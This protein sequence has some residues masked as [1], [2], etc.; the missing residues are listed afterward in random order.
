MA[1]LNFFVRSVTNFQRTAWSYVAIPLIY[2]F[3]LVFR[4]LCVA[5]FNPLFRA[6]G[7]GLSPAEIFFIGFAGL[8][9]AVSLI[10]VSAFATGTRL[11]N[12][13]PDESSLVN[14]DISLWSSAFVVLT[15]VI[16]G[17]LIAPLLKILK[18]NVVPLEKLKMRSRAKRALC[19]F[20]EQQLTDLRDD[21]DEFLQ[22]K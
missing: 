3:M 11:T 17:P 6:L 7:E 4:C 13:S 1:S 10:M 18:L 19:R 22:G 15:L 9:G 8:R 20:T 16:N 5:L 21:D 14:A 2:V 12:S